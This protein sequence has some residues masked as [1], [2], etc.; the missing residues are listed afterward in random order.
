[1][2]YPS[3]MGAPKPTTGKGFGGIRRGRRCISS[4]DGT[5]HECG[6]LHLK[7]GALPDTPRRGS[8]RMTLPQNAGK[9]QNKSRPLWSAAPNV[10]KKK[11]AIMKKFA[12]LFCVTLFFVDV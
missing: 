1:M 11:D 6:I 3:A 10:P 4:R 7:P 9:R 5:G 2:G 12:G 8:L